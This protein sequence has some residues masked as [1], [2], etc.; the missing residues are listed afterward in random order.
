MGRRRVHEKNYSFICDPITHTV[1]FE[2]VAKLL[3]LGHL[4]SEFWHAASKRHKGKAKESFSGAIQCLF[5][6]SIRAER[7]LQYWKK[8]RAATQY[9]TPIR[10][11]TSMPTNIGTIVRTTGNYCQAIAQLANDRKL[12]DTTE[13]ANRRN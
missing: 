12:S 2:V 8:I 5:L 6:L 3:H 10:L 4:E 7:I 13:Q 9:G 1:R 11:Y